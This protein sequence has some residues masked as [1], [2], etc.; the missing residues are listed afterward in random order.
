MA[1]YAIGDPHL[2]LGAEKPMDIF[3]GWENYAE[4]L[5]ENWR[6]AVS[7]EDT[8][9][10]AGDISWG[11]SLEES[12][13]DFEL[14]NALPGAKKLILKGNHDYWWNSASKMRAFFD[15]HGLSTLNLLHNNA[16]A[17]DG[18]AICGSRGWLFENGAPHDDKI[19]NREAIRIEASLKAAEGMAGERLLFLHYPPVFAGQELAR[20][21]G[22]MRQYGISRCFYGH[23]HGAQGHKKAV[24]GQYKG[25]CFGLLAADY[26][27][28]APL[29]IS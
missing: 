1:L 3:A 25:V 22:L 15:S 23:I 14:I 28:F 27:G 10:L 16:Y 11:M 13:P 24:T 20:F 5:A 9:V 4:K 19:I 18:F 17:L 29:R 7:P 21:I 26:L 12:L 2:S 6:A 8:V